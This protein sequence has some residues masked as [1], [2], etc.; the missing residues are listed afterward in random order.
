[1]L[2]LDATLAATVDRAKD[3]TPYAW[4]FRYP[5]TPLVPSEE[6]TQEALALARE[7]YDAVAVRLPPEVRP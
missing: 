2:A 7:V 6:D 3:L 4:R 1:V 5:G